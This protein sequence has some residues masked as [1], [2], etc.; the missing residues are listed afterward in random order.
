MIPAPYQSL[1]TEALGCELPEEKIATCGQCVMLPKAGSPERAGRTWFEGSTKCCTYLPR[2]PNFVVGRILR[3]TDPELAPGRKSVSGRIA[4]REAVTPLGLGQTA[5]FQQRYLPEKF[6][7]DT[8][9]RCPHY[10]QEAGGCAI[11]R[12]REPVCATYFCIHE[13]GERGDAFWAALRDFLTCADRAVAL[14]C[15]LGL[16]TRSD[17]MALA[18]RADPAVL[19]RG[20]NTS[21]S[22]SETEYRTLWG[23]YAAVVRTTRNA[24]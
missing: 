17:A 23:D 24:A 18:L 20:N 12:Y 5:D 3:D 2:L 19:R 15:L 16:D 13:R 7:A 1:A 6:G 11:W 21:P 10:L 8:T 22:I 4:A 14:H 9:L